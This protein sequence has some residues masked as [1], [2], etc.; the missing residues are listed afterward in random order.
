MSGGDKKRSGFQITSV[1]LDYGQTGVDSSQRGGFSEYSDQPPPQQ[2]QQQQ[3]QQ[4]VGDG[5]NVEHLPSPDSNMPSPVPV[6]PPRMVGS[7]MEAEVS[8]EP[9]CS[10]VPSTAPPPSSTGGITDRSGGGGEGNCRVG[11]NRP[12]LLD[13]P[14]TSQHSSSSSQ[15]CTPKFLRRQVSVEQGGAQSSPPS[16]SR[17]RVVRL[18]QGLGEPYCRGRWTCTDFLERDGPEKRGLRLVVESMR[19]AHSLDSLE[20]VELG[21]AREE[22]GGV[23][24]SPLAHIHAQNTRHQANSQDAVPVLPPHSRS[25]AG[26]PEKHF[27]GEEGKADSGAVL[28][29]AAVPCDPLSPSHM[30]QFRVKLEDVSSGSPLTYVPQTVSLQRQQQHSPLLSASSHPSE[31]GSSRYIPPRLHLDLNI[32][33]KSEPL[34][35]PLSRDGDPHQDMSPSQAASAFSLAQSMFGVGGAFDP[36]SESGSS[37]RIMAIDNK[38]EQAM[39]LVKTHLMLAVREEVDVLREQI[40]ELTERNTQ[41]ERENY[42]LRTLRER[43]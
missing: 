24:L 14:R 25:A 6:T 3:Q 5:Q 27:A 17:F 4:S 12:A 37:K 8:R 16:P 23:V 30:D 31:F 42:I 36:D 20:V 34:T 11:P 22:V 35:T 13:L 9:G 2:Q 39:D 32:L 21:G 26:S 43:D 10:V 41:L 38:I 33:G 40:M 1:T 15:P 18:G 29:Y 28:R 19:H 7:Q